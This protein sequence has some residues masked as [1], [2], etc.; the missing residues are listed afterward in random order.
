MNCL[1]RCLPSLEI[2]NRLNFHSVA[3]VDGVYR[4]FPA[5]APLSTDGSREL[6]EAFSNKHPFRISR[7]DAPNLD[8]R[9]KR[10]MYVTMATM[11]RADFL[12]ILDADEWVECQDWPAF[13][14]EL[15]A[16]KNT[17]FR[18]NIFGVRMLDYLNDGKTLEQD[19]FRPRLWYRPEEISYTDTHWSF[20]RVKDSYI[21]SR[22]A[23]GMQEKLQSP[24]VI[25][26]DHCCNDDKREDQRHDYE[27]EILPRLEEQQQQKKSDATSQYS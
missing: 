27:T 20:A 9:V 23:L 25:R 17:G 26:H 7:R 21:S 5:K 19:S 3:A 1:K 15:Y 13:W 18:S 24:L 16:I 11:V 8:E 12:L 2:N 14:Q 6:I 10:Q 4:G 22:N